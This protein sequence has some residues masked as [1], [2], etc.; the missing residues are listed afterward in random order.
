MVPVKV[1]HSM[2]ICLK[3]FVTIGNCVNG[4][5]MIN[6]TLTFFHLET[7][8]RLSFPD[9][10]INSNK[11]FLLFIVLVLYVEMFCSH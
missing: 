10:K 9:T 11:Q 1:I 8:V 5:I 4:V 3:C 6:M 2:V 7:H